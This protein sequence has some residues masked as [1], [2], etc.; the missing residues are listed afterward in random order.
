MRHIPVIAIAPFQYEGRA[1]QAGELVEV[2]PIEAA[3]LT[4]RRKAK[5]A[6]GRRSEPAVVVSEPE[7]AAIPAVMGDVIED[8]APRRRRR[9]RRRELDEDIVATEPSE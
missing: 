5:F 1:L 4:Y 8:E 6:N 2:R 7:P 3:M 9:Y